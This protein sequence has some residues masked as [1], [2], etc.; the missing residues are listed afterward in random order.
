[1]GFKSS[2]AEF[3]DV[4]ATA[5]FGAN[6]LQAGLG[7]Q[8]VSVSQQFIQGGLSVTNNPLDVAISGNGF[9]R[10]SGEGGTTSSTRPDRLSV[11]DELVNLIIAQRM[12]QANAQTIRAQEPDPANPGQPALSGQCAR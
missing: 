1:V 3:A 9:F 5:T 7:A 12:Y 4:Y 2:R 10:L 6:D 8:T 11:G